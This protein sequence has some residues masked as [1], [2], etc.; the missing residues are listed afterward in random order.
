MLQCTFHAL[1]ESLLQVST[2]FVVIEKA[3]V[4]VLEPVDRRSEVKG[5]VLHFTCSFKLKNVSNIL[6]VAQLD[7]FAVVID[8]LRILAFRFGHRQLL[9]HLGM[10]FQFELDKSGND[11]ENEDNA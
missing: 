7:I 11:W 8:R 9:T 1:T 10:S 6:I 5:Q 2:C 3:A 4:V